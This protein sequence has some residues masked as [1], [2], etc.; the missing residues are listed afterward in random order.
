[1]FTTQ[2]DSRHLWTSDYKQITEFFVESGMDRVMR[3]LRQL[4]DKDLQQQLWFIRG[5][6]AAYALNTGQEGKYNFRESPSQVHMSQDQLLNTAKKAGDRLVETAIRSQD[7][8]TWIGLTSFLWRD[9][10]LLPCGFDLYGGLPGI[11]LFL[12]YL[13]NFTQEEQYTNLAEASLAT[14]T[15][16]IDHNKNQITFIGGFNGWGGIIYML[17]HL[18]VLWEQ[19]ELLDEAEK[20]I[21]LLP[22]L[23][24]KDETYD[25]LGGAAGC[26]GSLL[27]LNQCR[28]K[29]DTLAAAIKCGDHLL[30]NAQP[31]PH[32]IGWQ[33]VDP[34]PLSGFAHGN[35][36]IA[37][38]LF[39]LARVSQEERF[40]T[41]AQAALTYERSLFV[42]EVG[43]W[44][45]LRDMPM[46][47]KMPEQ[48]KFTVAWCHGAPGI[49]LGRLASLDDLHSETERQEAL[50]E[51]E[52]SIQTT[53]EKGFGLNHSICHGDLGNLELILQA[54]RVLKKPKLQKEVG[55]LGGIVL[56]SIIHDGL[57]PGIPLGVETP[58]LMTGLA[59]IGYG[60][61]RLLDP[62][63]TPSILMLE[64][65][66]V[67][68]LQ[69]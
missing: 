36:G 2:P 47:K 50:S 26:I 5:S 13:G 21:D 61:L 44:Q 3:R 67:S 1:M 22:S 10:T 45:D 63:H 69:H 31:M 7:N 35:A 56:G 28:P 51:I 43:N 4:N 53:L 55:R 30:A 8:A 16:Q 38:A 65:P 12:A 20:F 62:V 42:A 32:G 59:G 52:V 25:V 14:V 68:A 27:A 11:T 33:T 9:W 64:P 39:R 19:P 54:G 46:Y 6:L 58:G 57:M 29:T 23:I 40:Y 15:E 17:T 49:G 37:W 66:K 24:S 34:K 18:G 41:A 48:D 60:L